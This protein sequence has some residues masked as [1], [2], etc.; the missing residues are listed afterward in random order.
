MSFRDSGLWITNQDSSSGSRA[1]LLVVVLSDGLDV[2]SH[3]N[4]DRSNI[5]KSPIQRTVNRLTCA[6]K[7]KSSALAE[8]FD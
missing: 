4:I 7:P 1:E 8:E 5:P 3:I 6:W 2:W